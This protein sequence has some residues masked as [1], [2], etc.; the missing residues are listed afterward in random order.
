MLTLFRP[1]Y[2]CFVLSPKILVGLCKNYSKIKEEKY[3]MIEDCAI[4]QII[5]HPL[6]VVCFTFLFSQNAKIDP[7]LRNI[8]QAKKQESERD[9]EREKRERKRENVLLNRRARA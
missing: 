7:Q 1:M 5:Q 3:L 2:M 9:G 6:S 4:S 8:Q